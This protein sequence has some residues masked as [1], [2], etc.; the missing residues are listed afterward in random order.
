MSKLVFYEKPRC[1]SNQRQKKYLRSLGIAF[2]VKNLLS[3][4]WTVENLR[5]FFGEEPIHRWFNSS[6][7]MVK[8]GEVDIR[9]IDAQHAL[10]WMINEPLL[11]RRPLLELGAIKQ[12][13]FEPGPVLSALKITLEPPED[14]QSCSS[15]KTE[16]DCKETG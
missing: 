5:S 3:E 15:P 7:P 11:I 13:G 6:A 8:S 4:P 1:I 14:L 16:M 2:E 9:R 12:S 10:K